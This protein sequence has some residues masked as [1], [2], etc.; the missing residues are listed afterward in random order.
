PAVADLA[1]WRP[2]IVTAGL[3]TLVLGAWRAL[4][5]SDLKLLLAHGTTSQL[6]LMIAMF[7]L[8]DPE[9]TLAGAVL[10][11]AHAAYKASAFMVVGIADHETGTRDLRRLDGL[12]RHLRWTFIVTTIAAASMAGL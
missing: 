8:G 11:L 1:P 6:G 5:Q 2:M 3:V 7:G 12:H 10:L 4:D 9:A